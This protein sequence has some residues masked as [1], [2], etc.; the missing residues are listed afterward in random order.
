MTCV[1]R[2][3]RDDAD[4]AMQVFAVVPTSEGLDPGLSIRLGGKALVRP[5]WAVFEGP[6]QG[7]R[8]WVVIVDLGGTYL[9]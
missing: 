5:F 4:G 2:I 1:A 6:E 7:F 8:E 3:R 9:V